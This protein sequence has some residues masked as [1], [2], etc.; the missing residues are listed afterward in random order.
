ML[1][2]SQRHL[3]TLPGNESG[4]QGLYGSK[5]VAEENDSLLGS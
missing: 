4:C 1:E 3:G 2:K 5:R